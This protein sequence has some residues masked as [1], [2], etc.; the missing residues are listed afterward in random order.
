[1]Q[2]ILTKYLG[3][4]DTKGPRVKAMTSSGHKGST[5]TT[6]WDDSLNVEGNHTYA[7]QKLLDRLD[8]LGMWRMGA[9]DRGF[10]F[11]NV[12]DH[13]SPKIMAVQHDWRLGK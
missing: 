6:T 9:T 5:Y 4:T 12:E 2:T 8:W 3:P 1:M 10:V 7:A 11:V 13:S